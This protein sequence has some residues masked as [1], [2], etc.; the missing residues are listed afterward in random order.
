M[1]QHAVP[2]VAPLDCSQ[3]WYGSGT[4]P[5][6]ES[7]Y[8]SDE[9]GVAWVTTGELRENTINKT[10]KYVTERALTSHSALKV[11]PAGSLIIAMYGATIGRLGVL[12]VN[13]ALNQACFAIHPPKTIATTFLRYW[14]EGFRSELIELGAGGGQPNIS[15]DKIRNLVVSAPCSED[16]QNKVIAH[17]DRETAR[18]DALISKKSRFIE[19]LRE[20]RQALITHA[21]TKG[22]DPN[23]KMK[24]SGVEWLGEVPED[25][26]VTHIKRLVSSISQGWSP[27]C[28]ARSPEEGEWGVLKVGCVNGGQFRVEE[29]KALPNSLE[30]R[31]ELAVREGDVLVSRANTRELVGSCAVVSRDFP[32]I[33]LCDKLYR[34]IAEPRKVLPEFLAALIA[35]H[36]RRIVEIEATGASS[37]MV[38]IAQSV[39]MDLAVAVPQ[40]TEQRVIVTHLQSSA[41]KL[42]LVVT[43]TERSIELLKERRSALISAAVTGQIDLRDEGK[44][45]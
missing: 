45:K 26:S 14:F 19:L 36:G 17:L 31:P 22:L 42:D 24:D 12:G 16:E 32:K 6:D 37:S 20:K 34:L 10:E 29:S 8:V 1:N 35:V 13:A 33:M 43:R 9:S 28:E 38:N 25:W 30:P 21:V 18:I 40:V 11:H 41:T 27:E 2:C 15:A 44:T 4:T 23:V 5:S 3:R 7:Y 39:I